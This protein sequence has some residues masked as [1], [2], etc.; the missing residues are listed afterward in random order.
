VENLREDLLRAPTLDCLEP[1]LR[2]VERFRGL[3]DGPPKF[4]SPGRAALGKRIESHAGF[5]IDPVTLGERDELI[6]KDSTDSLYHL[7]NL[8]GGQDRGGR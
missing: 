3:P 4:S 5:Q 8:S 1:V 2:Y 6:P 7:A